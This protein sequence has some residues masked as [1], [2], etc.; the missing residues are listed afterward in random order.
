MLDF[1]SVLY[2][3]FRHPSRSLRPWP[4][5]S[6]GRPAALAEP[7]G[8]AGVARA[9][10]DLQGCAAATLAASTLHLFW[11]LF[12]ILAGDSRVAIHVDAVAYPISGWGIERAAGHGVP[13]RRFPHH[14]PNGLERGAA[15]GARRGLRPIVVTDGLCPG[16]GRVGAARP[17]PAGRPPAG[18]WVVVDDTQALGVLGAAP[19]AA[20]PYGRRGGGAARWHGIAGPELIVVASLAKGF[21]V[22]T[23]RA[24]RVGSLVSRFEAAS[25]T[26]AHCSPPSVAALHAAEHAFRLNGHHG[27]ELRLALARLV[28]HFRR[29]LAEAGV[30][31]SGGLFPVQTLAPGPGLPA[32]ALHER[33]AA[34]GV[35]SVLHRPHGAGGPRV[36]FILTARH[37]RADVDAAVAAMHAA[38]ASPERNP[39][40]MPCPA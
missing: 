20:A 19:A 23:G 22:P 13:V 32:P 24:V 31:V 27:D 26:R 1:T 2:L 10:A 7:P 5:L 14:D 38:V 21:G 40:G 15:A 30:G 16:C 17:L 39:G 35:R 25:Q 18:G 34:G 37:T 3:G 9:L 11:D 12:L 8:A 4:A 33:L 29:R 28:R 6:A 36:G